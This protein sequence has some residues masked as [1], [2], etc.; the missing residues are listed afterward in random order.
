MK[1]K[2]QPV[3]NG[4]I[5][6]DKNKCFAYTLVELPAM[7]TFSMMDVVINYQAILPLN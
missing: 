7:G 6:L 3:M 2:Y 4:A 5:I 1:N